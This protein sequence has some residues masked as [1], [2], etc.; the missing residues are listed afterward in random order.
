ME[1]K[2]KPTALKRQQIEASLQSIPLFASLSGEQLQL[3]AERLTL[4]RVIKEQ[5]IFLQGDP[6]N[7]MYVVA[8]GRIRI[9]CETAGGREITLDVARTGSFFGDM[10]LLDGQERSASAIAETA[11]ELLVLSRLDFQSFLANNLGV[12]FS[13]LAFL[14]QRLRAADLKIQ[15]L[16]LLT[17]RERLAIVL[18]DLVFN[19]GVQQSDGS[20]LLPSE[21]S[22]KTLAG[23]LGASRE[24]VSRVCAEFKEANLISQEGRRIVVNA[25]GGLQA[26]CARARGLTL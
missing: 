15:D 3:L 19:D 8:R 21:V 26:I 22:H 18:V 13:L 25:I 24:T 20:I 23:F 1:A 10:A 14:S 4:R 2:I 9:S 16:A 5:P 7:E 11:G 12:V 17:V 6:G